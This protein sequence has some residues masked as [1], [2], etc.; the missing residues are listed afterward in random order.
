MGMSKRILF[1][2]LLMLAALAAG[3][4]L[5]A[6]AAFPFPQNKQQP[7]TSYNPAYS[8]A[9]VVSVY[10]SFLT[11]QV[12]TAGAGGFRRVRR[13]GD[14]TLQPDSTVSEGIGY[15]MIIAVYMNDQAKQLRSY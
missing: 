9:D 12:T 15:G 14:P 1:A 5:R 13:H 3:T 6:A 7:F 11:E 4:P 2:G 10:N 8:N